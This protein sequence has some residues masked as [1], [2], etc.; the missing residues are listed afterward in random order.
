MTMWD[1]GGCQ[2]CGAT[3][4][5]S[6][7]DQGLRRL[8]GKQDLRR[9]VG[10]GPD[11]R[12]LLP[13][14]GAGHPEARRSTGYGGDGRA[15]WGDRPVGVE[16]GVVRSGCPFPFPTPPTYLP[17]V[18]GSD[19]GRN[20]WCVDAG[21]ES[22]NEVGLGGRDYE[23]FAHLLHISSADLEIRRRTAGR[24]TQWPLLSS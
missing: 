2:A 17:K 1:E 22:V 3:P 10:R 23:G 14:K 6:F 16:L 24:R 21:Q 9:P 5:P 15:P 13:S 4:P 20:C 12:D 8:E 7:R 11:R 18:G 19:G